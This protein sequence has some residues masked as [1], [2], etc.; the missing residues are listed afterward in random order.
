[1]DYHCI[2]LVVLTHILCYS[3][4]SSTIFLFTKSSLSN[5]RI[6]PN[7]I[8]IKM[9]CINNI[10]TCLRFAGVNKL[11]ERSWY[12]IPFWMQ[13]MLIITKKKHFC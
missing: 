9:N 3:P 1:M 7:A 10:L 8:H 11:S 5:A 13:M 12:V 2:S 6:C 4:H